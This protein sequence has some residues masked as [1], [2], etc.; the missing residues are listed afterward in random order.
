MQLDVEFVLVGRRLRSDVNFSGYE[1]RA[2]DNLEK[3]KKIPN[4]LG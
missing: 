3:P 1:E 4:H 2:G